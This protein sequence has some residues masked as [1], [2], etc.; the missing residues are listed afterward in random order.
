MTRGQSAIGWQ[1]ITSQ[2]T[3]DIDPVEQREVIQSL[4][5]ARWEV[6]SAQVIQAE[7]ELF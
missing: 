2:L 1:V 4:L 6:I 3:V 5:T 7:I